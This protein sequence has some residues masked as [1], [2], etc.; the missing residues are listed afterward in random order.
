MA[1]WE[2]IS[3]SAR[4]VMKALGNFGPTV[5]ASA[6]EVKGYT[7]EDGEGGKQYLSSDDLRRIAAACEEVAEWL[8]KRAER[9]VGG[10]G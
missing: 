6:R 5:H 7:Y 10:D 1:N 8:D 2:D 3:A 4:D 9:E